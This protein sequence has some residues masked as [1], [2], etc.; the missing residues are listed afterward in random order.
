MMTM[1]SRLS[2]MALILAVI[3]C[4]GPSLPNAVSV[5]GTV[6]YQNKPVAGAQVVLNNTDEKGKPASGVTDAQ[7]N[8]W[9]QTYVDGVQVKG[10]MPGSYK[11]TV[12]KTEQ[13]T[14]SSEEMMK[15]SSGSNAVGPKQLLPKKYSSPTTT[16]LTAE[17]KKGGSA[18]LKLDLPD[19]E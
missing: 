4:G 5:S 7:G 18:P 3:G 17:V 8:F 11:V 12:T 9:V 14:M 13:S 10:A 15:A 19:S 1:F 6:S 16:T 2:G